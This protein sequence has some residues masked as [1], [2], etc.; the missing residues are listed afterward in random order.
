MSNAIVPHFGLPFAFDATGSA[1]VVEQDS[2]AD[3]AECV[4]ILA[5][6]NRGRR[7]E[8]PDYGITDPTFHTTFDSPELIAQVARYEPR[9]QIAVSGGPGAD[10][11]AQ[12]VTVN[13]A[14]LQRSS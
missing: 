1:T 11:L 5:A 2:L 6:C 10:V 7:I 14:L 8:L 13:V 9:A 12:Q 4:T 3:I